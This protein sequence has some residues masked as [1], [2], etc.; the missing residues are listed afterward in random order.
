MKILIMR[1]RVSAVVLTAFLTFVWG[2]LG[3]SHILDSTAHTDTSTPLLFNMYYEAD[4]EEDDFDD[5]RFWKNIFQQD[6][7]YDKF[8]NRPYFPQP[9]AVEKLVV[10]LLSSVRIIT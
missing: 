9:I 2:G 7:S 5:D 1:K 3:A 6:T 4:A 10:L 8:D